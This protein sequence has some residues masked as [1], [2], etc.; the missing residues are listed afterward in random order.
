MAALSQEAG[1]VSAYEH[2]PV[3]LVE[4]VFLLRPLLGSQA[5]ALLLEAEGV[6]SRSRC[7]GEASPSGVPQRRVVQDFEVSYRL[8]QVFRQRLVVVVP[9]N[10][11]DD[12]QELGFQASPRT[13]G[14]FLQMPVQRRWN[15]K[16]ECLGCH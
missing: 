10:S 4:Q 11:R 16:G 15:P 13:L 6:E 5:L 14:S 2:R 9:H 1:R 7:V 8:G 12:G 3:A